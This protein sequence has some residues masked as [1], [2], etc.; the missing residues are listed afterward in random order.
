MVASGTRQIRPAPVD[1]FPTPTSDLQTTT[2]NIL[3]ARFEYV[4]ASP[5]DFTAD[6]PVLHR[7]A[8]L[9]FLL[10]NLIQGFPARYRSQDA[11]QPWLFFW[12]L[13][14]FSVLGVGMDESTRKRTIETI[15][16]LQHPFGGFA[17]GPGQFPHL[18][19]T[20]ASVCALA[21]VGHPGENGAWDQIDR[22]KMYNFFMSLKQSDGSFL[23]SHHAE[24]DVRG[25]YCLLAVATMLDILTPELL[26]GTPEF[27]ASCQTYEGGFGSASFPDWALSNDGSVK[28]VSAPRPPLGEAHGGYTFCA[29]ASWV[30]LQPYI[31]TY[32]PA[33]SLSAPCID[34]HGLLRWVTHMQGSAI[35]LGG[36]KGRTNKLV[37]GC[38]SWWVGGCVVLVEGLLGIEKHSGG[39]E[40]REGED[41]N[42]HAWGDVD[43][44]LFNREA[45][46]EYVL[47]AGQHAAG[48]LIDKP[49]KP[50]DAYHTLY[51]L[52]GLSAAQHRVVPIDERKA[53]LLSA[54]VDAPSDRTKDEAT[55]RL[56]KRAFVDMLS[57]VEEEGT[58][59]YVGGAANRL[60]ATHPLLNLTATHVEAMMAHFYGQKTPMRGAGTSA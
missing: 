11:S 15:L 12:T 38:Y 23:V 60:N 53:E 48:G 2:E 52:S 44:S 13:Q 58:V 9:Q 54:W 25:I 39:K 24:V 45:L 42:E 19:P 14:G 29:T 28:D 41:S 51:C 7:N 27:I 36:F 3:K 26:T 43:D 16:A 33:R 49:P 20:Y 6:G 8:H 31:Q 17:G 10:R 40:G 57:W 4:K 21:I 55:S 35:E 37:D 1:G 5:N 46:Q 59:V 30:L 32:Y 50:A 34:I 47:I 56:R 22:K 18:L